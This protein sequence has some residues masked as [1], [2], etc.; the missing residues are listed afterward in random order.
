MTPSPVRRIR[1]QVLAAL[2][3][4]SLVVACAAGFPG[5]VPTGAWGGPHAGMVVSDTGAE[6]EYDCGA[7]RI[8]VPLALDAHGD[9]N[10]PGLYLREGPGPVP[11]D[12]SLIPKL[13]ARYTGH[14]NGKTMS[15]TMTVTDG[16]IPTQTYS[17]TYGGN[18][19]VF[20][21]L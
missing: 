3:A 4:T 15:L 9:F 1:R 12:D 13:A 6:I 8:T 10:L 18:P 7:G 21:C 20:K 2:T 5:R 16:S 17:L 14:T 19:N 11:A